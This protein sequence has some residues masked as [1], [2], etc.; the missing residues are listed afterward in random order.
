RSGN[1][2][3][4]YRHFLLPSLE[5]KLVQSAYVTQMVQGDLSTLCWVQSRI[6]LVNDD[7][8]GNLI[9]IVYASINFKDIMIASGRLNLESISDEPNNSSLIGME[10]VGFN[11][12][13]QRI[14]GMGAFGYDS[15]IHTA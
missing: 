11:K 12:N 6:S 4:S 14:M 2:W 8:E 5:P 7:D 3:G 1:I 9:R 13:G 10:F 15:D